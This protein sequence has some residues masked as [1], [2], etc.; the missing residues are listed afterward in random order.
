VAI[1][2]KRAAGADCANAPGAAGRNRGK[3][4]AKPPAR[5][6]SRA[7][8]VGGED[9]ERNGDA[10]VRVEAASNERRRRQAESP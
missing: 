1:D 9:A 3:P 8:A 6:G 7:F 10:F 5:V 4:D 2:G